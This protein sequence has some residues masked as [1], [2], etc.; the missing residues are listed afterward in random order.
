MVRRLAD[1]LRAAGLEVWFDQNEL[2]G[3]DAW[4][5]KIRK[6]IK[7]C[8]LFVPIV[9][10][11]TEARR[12]G[13]FRIEWKLAAQRT[14][15]IA[16]GTP[17]LVPV[18]ID[19]T[20]E[21]AALV[22][23]EFRHVQW[24]RLPAGEAT[25]RFVERVKRLLGGN[26]TVARG[27]TAPAQ[28]AASATTGTGA[29]GASGGAK[30]G[31]WLAVAAALVLVAAGAVWYGQKKNAPAA[32]PAEKKLAVLP[33]ET[34]GASENDEILSDGI[35]GELL[36]LLNN[37]VPGLKVLWRT[38]SFSFKDQN[39]TGAEIAQKLGVNY[40]VTGTF[41]RVGTQV[42]ITASLVNAADDVML[43]RQSFNKELKEVLSLQDEMAALIAQNLQL[44]LGGAVRVAKIVNPEAHGLVQKGK[45]HWLRRS[46]EDLLKAEKAY[47]AAIALAPDYADAHVGLA[48]TCLVRAWYG[49]LEG[50]PVK[51]L[52]R[53]S[54]AAA[55]EALRLNANL[56]EARA[57]LGA[58]NYNE[59]LFTESEQEFQA[60]LRLNANY[61]F[62]HHWRAHLLAAQGR[63]DLAIPAM[64]RATEL[65]PYALSTLV[66]HANMLEYAG[67]YAD[68]LAMVDRA[69]AVGPDFMP[70][71]GLRS[72][73]LL[74][75]GRREEAV[76]AAKSFI[77]DV[78]KGPR[79]WLD[80]NA[81]QVLWQTDQREV[82][83]SHEQ[84]LRVKYGGDSYISAYVAAA[85]G[86]VDEAFDGLEKVTVPPTARTSLFYSLLWVEL[87]RSPRFM[88]LMKKNG[89]TEHYQTARATLEKMHPA[90]GRK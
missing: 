43:W 42:R 84:K 11:R 90:A 76:V 28:G 15:A 86:R 8:A 57:V 34:I 41:H 70:C 25:P 56:A 27:G 54:R 30:I 61:P 67:R 29:V 85:L 47:E 53:R 51:D 55:H 75:V 6:Q 13:Y 65:D 17:F 88:E 18:V 44:K 20:G 87:R 49:E 64:E 7:E 24:T 59:G 81:I 38:S 22:P 74:Q 2:V 3:G 33:F 62:A 82:A 68:A 79:W 66:I 60:A 12:E 72:R 14:H 37:N 71:Q 78:A 19:A 1:A 45:F 63:L 52:F 58:L 89:W 36:T 48:E 21:G 31:R 69:L 10:A 16:D 5:A 50:L 9:S 80:G 35:A 32:A 39:L 40:F 23:E 4:D 73:N 77:A 26:A 46:T 83:L